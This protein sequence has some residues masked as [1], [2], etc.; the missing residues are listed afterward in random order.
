MNKLVQYAYAAG[1]SIFEG[2][3]RIVNKA[4][5]I[6]IP[7]YAL[8]AVYVAPDSL[9]LILNVDET[10]CLFVTDSGHVLSYG[11]LLLTWYSNER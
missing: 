7:E 4:G 6:W 5:H 1:G 3:V 2:Q 8:D 10:R 9:I 11:R